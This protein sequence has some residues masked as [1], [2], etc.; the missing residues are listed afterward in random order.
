MVHSIA[1][2]EFDAFV[3]S[4]NANLPHMYLQ[5]HTH[6]HSELRLATGI[7]C[8]RRLGKCQSAPSTAWTLFRLK[9]LPVLGWPRHLWARLPLTTEAQESAIPCPA[10]SRPLLLGASALLGLVGTHWLHRTFSPASVCTPQ[11]RL[12]PTSHASFKRQ[13]LFRTSVSFTHGFIMGVEVDFWYSTCCW[14]RFCCR[15]VFSFQFHGC[16]LIQKPLVLS[17]K[18]PIWNAG[19]RLCR[20]RFCRDGHCH[21]FC[22]AVVAARFVD[23]ISAMV[24][25][26]HKIDLT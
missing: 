2:L 12:A 20:R 13:L 7:R 24:A 17:F 10:G 23:C 6:G 21:C 15:W 19:L 22:C 9:A 18:E 4:P 26:I 3:E 8:I 25:P 14:Y 11:L 5:Q 16:L 1:F